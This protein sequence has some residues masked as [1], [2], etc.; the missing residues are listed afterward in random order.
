M[1]LSRLIS[2]AVLVALSGCGEEASIAQS[3]NPRDGTPAAT[4]GGKVNYIDLGADDV[5]ISVNGNKLTK[6]EVERRLKLTFAMAKATGKAPG[7]M[8]IPKVKMGFARRVPGQFTS[9][10]LLIGAAHE[11]G[12]VATASSRDYAEKKILASFGDEGMDFP[13]FRQRIPANLR[14]DLESMIDSASLIQEYLISEAGEAAKIT[15]K[16]VDEVVE[17]GQKQKEHSIKV[18]AEQKRKAEEIYSKLLNGEDFTVLAKDSFTA[19][20]DGGVGDW[21]EFTPGAIESLYPGIMKSLEPLAA[22][23]FTKPL[24]FDDG[25]FIVQLVSREGSPDVSVFSPDPETLTL[26]RIVVPL[27][28]MY[29][30]ATRDEIR[31]SLLAERLAALQKETILPALSAKARIERPNGTVTFVAPKEATIKEGK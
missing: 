13:Q 26:K 9:E 20:E 12:I 23:E 10:I 1:N 4:E 28:V 3:N 17:F 25:I 31:R 2:F 5:I 11:K 30:V 14:D 18:L 19:E 16:E 8:T 7:D 29:E 22:G 6:N 21:G 27:P 15:E 24:E